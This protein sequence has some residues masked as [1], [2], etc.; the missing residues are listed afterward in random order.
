MRGGDPVSLARASRSHFNLPNSTEAEGPV[1]ESDVEDSQ[2]KTP[3]QT[4]AG[5]P[6]LGKSQESWKRNWAAAS[7]GLKLHWVPILERRARV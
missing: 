2:T 6:A 5:N 1:Q 7:T 4:E 3:V